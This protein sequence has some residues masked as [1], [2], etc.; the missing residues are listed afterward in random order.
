MSMFWSGVLAGLFGAIIGGG[1]TCWAAW[2]QVRGMVNAA[3]LEIRASAIHANRSRQIEL[4]RHALAETLR[5]AVVTE[6]LVDSLVRLHRH[7]NLELAT[8]SA[9]D[10]P[11]ELVRATQNLSSCVWEYGDELLGKEAADAVDRIVDML[12]GV[13]FRD[14]NPGRYVP[15]APDK[16]TNGLCKYGLAAYYDLGTYSV[17]ATIALRD[18]RN[19]LHEIEGEFSDC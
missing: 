4:K 9:A 11:D 7:E 8:C 2:I 6:R 1:F 13:L 10:L 5:A 12:D 3:Q 17:R 16:G 19:A 15:D 14:H 18:A